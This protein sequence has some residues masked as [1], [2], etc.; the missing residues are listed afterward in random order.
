MLL[1]IYDN[2][3][4]AKLLSLYY[5]LGTRLNIISIITFILVI[6]IG[7]KFCNDTYF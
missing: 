4:I 1:I 3:A 7:R 5:I 2:Y 6:F